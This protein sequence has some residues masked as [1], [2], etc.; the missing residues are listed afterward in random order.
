MLFVCGPPKCLLVVN[1]P[2]Y[3]QPDNLHHARE[4]VGLSWPFAKE[5]RPKMNANYTLHV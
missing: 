1:L 5:M 2:N 4:D 3:I